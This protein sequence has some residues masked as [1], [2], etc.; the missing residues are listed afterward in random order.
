MP[1][2]QSAKKALRQ[3]LRRH[4][5][6]VVRKEKAKDAI[7]AFRKLVAEKKFDEARAYISKLYR[8]VDKAAKGGKVFNMN[9]ARRRKSRLVAL[10]NRS[11]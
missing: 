2:T 10:L 11:G 4:A 8:A 6:N 5:H 7:R 9:T 1:I 3:S